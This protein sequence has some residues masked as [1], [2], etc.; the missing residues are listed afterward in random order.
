MVK[1]AKKEGCR[2]GSQR[3]MSVK[4]SKTNVGQVLK[5]KDLDRV[6]NVQRSMAIPADT[7]A[8]Q[9]PPETRADLAPGG[10]G[11]RSRLPLAL[12]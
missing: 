9:T 7:I 4:F 10:S 2:S 6:S 5:E 1:D 11:R 3:K 8:G 12:S